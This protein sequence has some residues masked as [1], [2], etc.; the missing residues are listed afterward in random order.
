MTVWFAVFLGHMFWVRIFSGFGA[1]CLGEI[2][3]YTY[4]V[5]LLCGVLVQSTGGLVFGRRSL[6]QS[7][8]LKLHMDSRPLFMNNYN[9]RAVWFCWQR[10]FPYFIFAS[11]AFSRTSHFIQNYCVFYDRIDQAGN[12]ASWCFMRFDVGWSVDS[13]SHVLVGWPERTK[14][15]GS[16]KWYYVH[17]I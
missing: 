4:C 14:Q 2:I 10:R 13:I 12:P 1:K 7:I 9:F 3:S 5:S 11:Y 16:V 15:L 8:G 6:W 17:T